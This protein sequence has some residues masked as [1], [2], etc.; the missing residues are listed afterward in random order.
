MQ[1]DLSSARRQDIEM[2]IYGGLVKK[3]FV[4]ALEHEVY[5]VSFSLSLTRRWAVKYSWI[6]EY[7]MDLF[8]NLFGVNGCR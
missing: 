5:A 4:Q 8:A 3:C 6:L 7:G 1:T 2:Q